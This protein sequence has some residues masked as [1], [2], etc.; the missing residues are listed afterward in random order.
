M[1]GEFSSTKYATSSVTLDNAQHEIYACFK[2]YLFTYA[3]LAHL[4]H[5][6]PSCLRVLNNLEMMPILV[7]E[8]KEVS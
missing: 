4:E 1:H 5:L 8:P 6:A 7:S 3:A 2:I